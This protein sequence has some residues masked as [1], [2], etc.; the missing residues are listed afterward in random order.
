[1]VDADIVTHH[2][3][4]RLYLLLGLLG[5]I[6]YFNR[7][8]QS[9]ERGAVVRRLERFLHQRTLTFAR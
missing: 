7:L 1:M 3:L 8:G 6:G 4:I 2:D 5:Q 9:H